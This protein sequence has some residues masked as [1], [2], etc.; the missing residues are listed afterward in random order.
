MNAKQGK[1]KDS[2]IKAQISETAECQRQDK[3]KSSQ[4]EEKW[5]RKEEQ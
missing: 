5:P 4:G 1:L 3:L 2:H